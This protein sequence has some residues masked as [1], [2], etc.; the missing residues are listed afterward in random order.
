MCN[1]VSLFVDEIPRYSD[2]IPGA[3]PSFQQR[4]AELSS[5]EQETIR[6]EKT[7]KFK[8]KVKDTCA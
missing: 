3:P 7:R 2:P 1:I 4:I 6:Y 8:K 5:L